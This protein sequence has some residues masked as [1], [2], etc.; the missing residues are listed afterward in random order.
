MNMIVDRR[1]LIALLA[2]PPLTAFLPPAIL[3]QETNAAT[4]FLQVSRIITATDALTQGV[5]DRVESLM[6]KRDH[7]FAGRLQKLSALLLQGEDRASALGR[8]D[9]DNLRFA[10]EIAKPWYVG[11]LGTPSNSFLEDDAEFATYLEAQSYQKLL[12]EVPRPS[13]PPGSAGWWSAVPDGVTAP[14]M[15]TGV[16]EW[17]FHPPGRAAEILD[18]APAWLSYVKASHVDVDAARKARPDAA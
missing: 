1:T 13:F 3:A 17:S 5:A 11:Y 14:E 9:P 8:L 6:A 10:I 4:S 15:P 2:A 16:A 7:Q 12:R 18:P